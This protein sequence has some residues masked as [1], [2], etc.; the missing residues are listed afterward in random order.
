MLYA[1]GE[2]AGYAELDRRAMPDIELAYFGL[3]PAFIG[4]RLGP[5]LLHWAIDAAWRAKPAALLG[6]HLQPRPS[7]ARSP[8][9]SARGSCP[10]D[11]EKQLIADPRPLP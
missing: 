2:P 8:C 1:A 4:R 5:W 10:I 3:L 11:Q 7:Q 9:T 6:P